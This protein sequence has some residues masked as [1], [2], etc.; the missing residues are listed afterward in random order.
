MRSGAPPL[1]SARDLAASWSFII[2]ASPRRQV[3]PPFLELPS[4]AVRAL[5]AVTAVTVL[6]GFT[7]TQPADAVTSC[8]SM[9]GECRSL[10]RAPAAPAGWTGGSGLSG[11]RTRARRNFPICSVTFVGGAD[12]G[13]VVDDVVV[14]Q[15][16]PAGVDHHVGPGG[17]LTVVVQGRA[18][19]HRG[20]LNPGDDGLL[21]AASGAAATGAGTAPLADS[22]MPEP[23][24]LGLSKARSRPVASAA[25]STAM[26]VCQRVAAAPAP[27]GWPVS[28]VV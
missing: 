20:R 1:S 5:A 24:D 9:S 19:G 16:Q 17:R 12:L 21:A 14:G 3:P 10:S 23:P 2:L 8:G 15:H 6:E 25:P 18:D 22:E 28:G 7:L 27:E 11:Q 4:L 26:T 13:G